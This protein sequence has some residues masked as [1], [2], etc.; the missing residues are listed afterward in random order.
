[1][2]V[3]PNNQLHPHE[4]VCANGERAVRMGPSQ[5]SAIDDTYGNLRN[6]VWKTSAYSSS[7]VRLIEPWKRML[8]VGRVDPMTC[9]L[10]VLT[11][12]FILLLSSTIR[13]FQD[14]EKEIKEPGN[15]EDH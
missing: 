5:S 3:F 12:D 6:P 1:M 8:A 2:S 7:A 11:A 4:F 10:S 13:R 15:F 14:W 9:K